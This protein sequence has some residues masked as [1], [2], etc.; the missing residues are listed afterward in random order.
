VREIGQAAD[1]VENDASQARA[2][3]AALELANDA[4]ATARRAQGLV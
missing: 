4:L 1:R 3:E 2:A